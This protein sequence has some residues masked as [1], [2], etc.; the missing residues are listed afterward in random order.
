[1]TKV[2]VFALTGAFFILITLAACNNSSTP[3]KEFEAPQKVEA[4]QEK[5]VVIG[6]KKKFR[7]EASDSTQTVEAPPE[8]TVDLAVP[9]PTINNPN[10]PGR[11]FDKP[12]P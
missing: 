1:M 6:Y 2:K 5:E 7:T 8:A 3:K 12:K 10:Q 11:S 9:I 4:P